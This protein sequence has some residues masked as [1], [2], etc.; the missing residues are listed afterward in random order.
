MCDSVNIDI[1]SQ[2]Q[3]VC[4]SKLRMTYYVSYTISFLQISV[5]HLSQKNNETIIDA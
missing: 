1:G 5:K 3:I 4:I 2:Q